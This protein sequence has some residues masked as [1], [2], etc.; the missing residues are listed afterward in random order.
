MQ[1]AVVDGV[2]AGLRCHLLH[3][4]VLTVTRLPIALPFDFV[5]I[6]TCWSA[7]ARFG[8]ERREDPVV[9]DPN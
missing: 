7:K 9:T 5:L 1:A 4:P 3:L 2:E 8:N 6:T